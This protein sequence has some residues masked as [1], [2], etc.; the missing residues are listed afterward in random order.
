M[1]SLYCLQATMPVVESNVPVSFINA[2][3]WCV[4]DYS[5]E[6]HGFSL[7]NRL[8]PDMGQFLDEKFQVSTYFNK[9][10]LTDL[11]DNCRKL[12]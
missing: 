4:Q 5:W 8:L 11:G 7:V 3:A 12:V 9:F 6:D 1:V 10:N 2:F